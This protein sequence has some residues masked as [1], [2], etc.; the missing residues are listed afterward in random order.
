MEQHKQRL[1]L[2]L[3]QISAYCILL[4]GFSAQLSVFNRCKPN[5]PRLSGVVDRLR[6]LE[7]KGK[8]IVNFTHPA[9]KQLHSK[10]CVFELML[11]L[12]HCTTPIKQ[13]NAPL[14]FTTAAT[15]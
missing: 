13:L 15:W 14:I 4:I 3:A 1:T 6:D 11:S 5:I 12:L 8:K 7:R 10:F 9:S 2:F